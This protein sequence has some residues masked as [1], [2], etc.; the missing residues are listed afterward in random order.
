MDTGRFC[1]LAKVTQQSRCQD[2]LNQGGFARTTDTSD[3]HP[4][5]QRKLDVQVLQ[6]VFACAFQNQARCGVT[7]QAF[8][9][10]TDLFARTQISAGQGV[11]LFQ[12]IRRAVKHHLATTLAGSGAHVH[13]AVGGQ[14]DCRV[15]LDHH[16]GVARIAQPQHGLG[17]AVHVTRVQTNAGLIQHEQGVDQGGAQGG[18]E[19]DALHFAATEGT[20]LP[21]QA[22]V[23]NA[24][25]TQVFQARADFFEQ[26]MQ[27]LLF[28][29]HTGRQTR[30]ARHVIEKSSQT[31]NRQQHQVVQTQTRQRF[32]LAACPRRAL[33][34]KAFV[35]RQGS[36]STGMAADAPQQTFGLQAR[37]VA[38]TA[39]GVTAVLGQ[40]HP[41]VHLVGL[42][43]QVF[44]EAFD[45]IPL[46]VPFAI[47]VGRAFDDPL[48]LLGG[49][50]VPRCVAWNA[51]GF[52]VA[53]QVVLAFLP[54]W[55]LHGFDGTHAQSEFVVGNHQAIVDPNDTTKT[56][57]HRTRAGGRVER[58]HGRCGVAVAQ[59]A[60]GTMQAGGI[61]KGFAQVLGGGIGLHAKCRHAAIATLQGQF[62][63]LHG[64]R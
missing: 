20:A 49:E 42:G 63:R 35:G 14:H 34:Q 64:A 6:I 39:S 48:T 18:C 32:E 7:H 28:G 13:N 30:I 40:Q 12:T 22:E 52:G 36:Q 38:F 50:L 3:G 17:D 4:T 25:I 2:V 44:K 60:I 31:L 61:S 58:E 15:V 59:I 56:L 55:C 9:A 62:N 57:A 19:V 47:P 5:L 43:F 16:Q 26:Q 51:S 54:R 41:D 27:G 33:R 45:A 24:H 53:H 37:A 10:H 23:T 21:I 29:L 46:L 11:G 1:A 8:E